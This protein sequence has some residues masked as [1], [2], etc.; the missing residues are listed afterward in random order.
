MADLRRLE[1]RIQGIRA[2]RHYQT[3]SFLCNLEY[4][5]K[6]EYSRKRLQH[7]LFWKQRSRILWLTEGD[8]NTK[9]FH[10]VAKSNFRRNRIHY[11]LDAAGQPVADQAGILHLCKDSFTLVYSG[12]EPMPDQYIAQALPSCISE[13]DNR[14]LSAFPSV[15]DIK[16]VV[17][18]IHPE[19]SPGPDGLNALFFQRYWNLVG[20]D[21]VH[22]VFE[23][24]IN[25]TLDPQVNET[26]I[27]LL[28]KS[29]GTVRLDDYRPIS[30]YYNVQ[31]K[32]ISKILVH[33]LCPML[34]KCISACQGAF[35][36]ANETP[37]GQYHHCQSALAYY[38]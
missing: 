27:T 15:A 20:A 1:K 7:E 3:S 30:L 13:E 37:C 36:L 31:Y 5:L 32:I 24:F 26:C 4:D 10:R 12:A 6:V 17:F 33:R 8:R 18:S 22:M 23:F 34:Q 14:I 29:P 25:G 19:K 9:F 11:L 2:S 35:Y 28:P 16:I 38:E 21:V